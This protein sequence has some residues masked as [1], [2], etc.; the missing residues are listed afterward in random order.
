MKNRLVKKLLERAPIPNEL[1]EIIS[2]QID[3]SALIAHEVSV[4]IAQ[5]GGKLKGE[6]KAILARELAA[7]LERIDVEK[8]IANVLENLELEIRIGFHRKQKDSRPVPAK[9]RDRDR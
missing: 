7:F 5:Q 2:D 9:Y 6:L 4:Q 1:K 8:A 3:L